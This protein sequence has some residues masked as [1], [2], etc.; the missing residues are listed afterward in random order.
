VKPLHLVRRFVWSLNAGP[1]PPEDDAWAR[2]Q[3]APGE[4][5][6][7]DRMPAVDRRHSI[8]VARQTQATLGAGA[9][10]PPVMAAALLH[11][12]GKCDAHLGTFGR[13]AA[14]LVKPLVKHN[15]GRL[16]RYARYQEVGARMLEAA[17]SDPLVV[18]WAREHHDPPERWTI[19]PV[20]GRALQAADNAAE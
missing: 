20:I 14:T 17:G 11:D 8:A 10:T 16:G 6:L 7:W 19:D 5:D 9:A 1:P 3:L 4:A 2:A 18:A 13:S 15:P 12:V